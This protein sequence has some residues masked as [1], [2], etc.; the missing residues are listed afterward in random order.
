MRFRSI[1][2]RLLVF[3]LATVVLS[4][5]AAGLGLVA[6]FGWHV[7]RRIGAELD[8][9]LTQLVGNLRFDASGALYVERPPSDA[10]FAQIHS[11]LYWQVTDREGNRRIR[12]RSLWDALLPD[13]DGG[14]PAGQV[15]AQ[16]ATGP[17]GANL[18]VHAQDVVVARQNQP[19]PVTVAAA[20]NVNEIEVLQAGFFR[21]LAPG[22]A[23]LG[24]VLLGCLW[25]QVSAGLRPVAAVAGGVNAIRSGQADRLDIAN[26]PD[27]IASLVGEVNGLLDAQQA[28]MVKARDRAADMAHGLKTPLAALM[29]DVRR[30]RERGISDVAADV[31]TIA[32]RM[33]RAIERELARS[34]MRHV[35][36]AMKRRNLAAAAEALTATL[37][38][39]PSGEGKEFIIRVPGT[40]SVMV[41][42]DDLNDLLGNLLENA[43]KYAG[44]TVCV[45]ASVSGRHAEIAIEDD[46]IGPEPSEMEELVRRGVRGDEHSGS[47]LGLAITQ[48]ILDE[49][50]AELRFARSTLGGLLAG[51]SLPAG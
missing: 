9:H 8:N 46:G 10:R 51:F 22:L 42:P 29:S 3:A 1:R 6:L 49:Y 41:D 23:F 16:T 36:G 14:R 47:G 34:R 37:S 48:D 13:T 40:I 38:R 18:L 7:E 28:A 19:H 17:D 33:Q 50:G 39:T 11:G 4:L 25:V 43:V 35:R 2:L 44:K 26:V 15:Q 32:I 27:E 21:D 24:A 45:Q 12:S 5:G 20:I 31:E 30:L